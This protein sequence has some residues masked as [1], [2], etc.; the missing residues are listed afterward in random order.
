MGDWLWQGIAANWLYDLS[1]VVGA[2]VLAF[3]KAK[4][5]P[6]ATPW[7]FALLG[8]AL[9]AVIAVSLTYA[10]SGPTPTRATAGRIIK[11]WSEHQQFSVASVSDDTSI[12]RLELRF[13][14]NGHTVTVRQP[15]NDPDF[16][17]IFGT[18][19]LSDE[20]KK[21]LQDATEEQITGLEESV[22]LE[23]ARAKVVYEN[24]VR[25]FNNVILSRR[26]ELDSA[27]TE[28]RFRDSVDDIDF[29]IIVI[30]TTFRTQIR[31]W[32]KPSGKP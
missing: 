21:R 9:G 15:K 26:L 30:L 4:K 5:S 22:Q 3:L 29:G 28:G 16:L 6:W 23:L 19:A 27:L 24:A 12:F 32:T 13:R 8:V 10:G 7:L 1:A 14:R 25:P 20:E 31:S 18:V 11:D 17:L 2:A